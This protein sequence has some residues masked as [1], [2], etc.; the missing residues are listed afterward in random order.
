[1]LPGP[2]PDEDRVRPAR[3]SATATPRIE[4]P[5]RSSALE[6]AIFAAGPV[7]FAAVLG[8]V[9]TEPNVATW[10]AGLA[11][12]AFT[13][14]DWVF[15]PVWTGLYVTMIAAVW[16]ILARATREPGGR[17]ALFAFYAQLAL[18]AAW[19]WAFFWS[20]SPLAGLVVIVA[21]LVAIAIAIRAF[22]PIDRVAAALLV[23]YALW[24]GYATVLNAAIYAMNR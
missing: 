18:N 1:M 17:R 19:S 12:P 15:G 20:R 4:R 9:A 10:Y 6:H 22:R 16:R 23:P 5:R 3:Q 21:L 11:K 8:R 24:V 13:P 7:V 2:R 14:P